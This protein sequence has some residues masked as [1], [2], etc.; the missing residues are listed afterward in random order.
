MSALAGGCLLGA[1]IE[2]LALEILEIVWLKRN[3]NGRIGPE[4][5]AAVLQF[6]DKFGRF[7]PFQ[8]GCGIRGSAGSQAA[9]EPF[10]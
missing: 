3:R 8:R 4:F 7:L 2:E 9:V 1:F 6:G 5:R 10:R